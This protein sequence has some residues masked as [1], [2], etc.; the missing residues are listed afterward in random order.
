MTWRDENY[1]EN[2]IGETDDDRKL[3]ARQFDIRKT[4]KDVDISSCVTHS[5]LPQYMHVLCT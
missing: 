5:I 2:A 1:K 3:D 4:T